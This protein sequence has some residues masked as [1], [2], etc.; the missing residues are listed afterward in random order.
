MSVQTLQSMVA[1]IDGNLTEEPSLQKLSA[2]V[3]YSPCYCSAKFSEY[4]NI[5]YKQYVS[6]RKIERAAEDVIRGEESLLAIALRFGFS[7]H[8]AFTRSF[9]SRFGCTP[10]HYRNAHGALGR[11]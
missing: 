9:A 4:M 3:G 2:Y 7:S 11:E 5:G 10:K 1:W 6:R 8:E